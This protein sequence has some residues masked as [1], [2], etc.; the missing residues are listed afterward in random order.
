MGGKGKD[1][2]IDALLDTLTGGDGS[3]LNDNQGSLNSKK[4]SI[5]SK[6]LTSNRISDATKTASV[7]TSRENRLFFGIDAVKSSKHGSSDL[8]LVAD[9]NNLVKSIGE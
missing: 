3:T 9:T 8:K 7:S 4:P 5:L 1:G 2:N 6:A